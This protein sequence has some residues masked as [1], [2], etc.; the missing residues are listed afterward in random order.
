[1]TTVSFD[2]VS[3]SETFRVHSEAYPNQNGVATWDAVGT[4]SILAYTEGGFWRVVN[5]TAADYLG[6]QR[7]YL[8]DG[9]FIA[10]GVNNSVVYVD[11]VPD[12]QPPQLSNITFEPS[13]KL[14]RAHSH[15]SF[16]ISPKSLLQNYSE[17]FHLYCEYFFIW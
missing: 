10:A 7:T 11:S 6:H 16:S 14:I 3:P 17:K 2:L 5:V 9:D 12:Y 13:C 8:N 15:C 4:A 1:V